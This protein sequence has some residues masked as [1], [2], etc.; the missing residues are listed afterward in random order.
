MQINILSESPCGAPQNL[1]GYV[2]QIIENWL[3][4]AFNY[5]VQLSGSSTPIADGRVGTNQSSPMNA[6]LERQLQNTGLK[7]N[8]V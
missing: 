4:Y 7:R 3:N 2:Q 1:L 8:V 5:K 6:A